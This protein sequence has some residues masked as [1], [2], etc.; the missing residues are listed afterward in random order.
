MRIA[1][2]LLFVVSLAALVG[3]RKDNRYQA[4]PPAHVKVAPAVDRMLANGVETTAVIEGSQSI[5]VKPRIEGYLQ[6]IA[7]QPGQWVEEGTVLFEIDS[8]EYRARLAQANA[9]ALAQQAAL[10][11]ATTELARQEQLF[12]GQATTQRDLDRARDSKSEAQASVAA[13][14]AQ[15]QAYALDV[16]FCTIKAPFS[17]RISRQTVDVGSYVTPSQTLATLVNDRLVRVNF[18]LT[19]AEVGT[20]RRAIQ[21]V[22]SAGDQRTGREIAMS[23]PIRLA[24]ADDRDFPYVGRLDSIENQFSTGTGTVTVYAL[25]ENTSNRLSP[26]LT[27]RVQVGLPASR[28]IVV[29]QVAL[30]ID[31]LG[32]FVYVVGRGNR[33]ERKDV[34]VGGNLGRL[35]RI[36]E[37]LT[38]ND[39]VIIEGLLRVRIGS[40]VVAQ[41][42]TLAAEGLLAGL[43][44]REAADAQRAVAPDAGAPAPA[45]ADAGAAPAPATGMQARRAQGGAA[46]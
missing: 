27:A 40:Q 19:E 22:R 30:G 36:D 45:A 9:T 33:V 7:F 2:T 16:E 39:R 31:Q 3:C 17:G 38:A 42:T 13:A 35:A 12:E 21:A 5:D 43:E 20:V 28:S 26:G 46:R 41:E 34:V 23:L 15:A 32:R 25:F 14:R 24:L 6:R 44:V 8:R 18:T 29:P 1:P 11:N 37:G 4:P 10:S